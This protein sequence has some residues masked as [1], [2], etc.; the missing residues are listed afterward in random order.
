MFCCREFNEEDNI[1]RLGCF[2]SHVFHKICIDDWFTRQRTCPICIAIIDV[3]YQVVVNEVVV[4]EVVDE[5]VVDEVVVDE[6]VVDEV[7]FEV[8]YEVEYEVKD[9]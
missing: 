1:I 9:D 2:H 4:D 7:V 5:V 8:E 6:V 3:N